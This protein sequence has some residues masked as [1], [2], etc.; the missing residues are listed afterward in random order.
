MA[1]RLDR[2][3]GRELIKSQ[4]LSYASMTTLR[5]VRLCPHSQAEKSNYARLVQPVQFGWLDTKQ[6]REHFV[7]VF[8]QQRRT[9]DFGW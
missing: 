4:A 2:C 6:R 1:Y 8:P 9:S 5:P 3:D 7:G